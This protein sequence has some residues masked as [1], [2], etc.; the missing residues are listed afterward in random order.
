MTDGGRRGDLNY[1]SA[2][3][4]RGDSPAF[5]PLSPGI[6]DGRLL[7]VQMDNHPYHCVFRSLDGVAVVRALGE[8]ATSALTT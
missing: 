1:R 8:F 6:R 4:H 5:A 7:A 2:A 3:R